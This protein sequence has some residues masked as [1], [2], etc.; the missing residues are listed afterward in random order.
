[1]N[2]HAELF[3]AA[4]G[5]RDAAGAGGDVA[6]QLI[7]YRG[8]GE[9]HASPW[10]ASPEELLR[11]MTGVSCR[12][13]MTQIR[14][15]L[16]HALVEAGQARIK[17]AV[18]VG[19]ACEEPQGALTAVAGRLAVYNVPVFVFQE[20]DDPVAGQAFRAIA[21]ITG[22]AHAPF[23]PGSAEQ[24]RALFGAVARYAAH[25]RAGLDEIEHQLVR[26]MLA[27]LPP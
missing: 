2:L 17:A 16:Q 10:S 4:A 25:G 24:L 19:D 15:V 14:R 23:M 12:G 13:G 1:M 3:R 8:V 7:H 11:Q 5:E 18:F 21:G 22:G 20:G 26:G 6:V 9:F 27:Q